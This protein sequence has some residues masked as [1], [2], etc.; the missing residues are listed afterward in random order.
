M[1]PNDPDNED[2]GVVP[3]SYEAIRMTSSVYVEYQDGE[4]L[5]REPIEILRF[6]MS[7]LE[8][9]RSSASQTSTPA[10]GRPGASSKHLLLLLGQSVPMNRQRFSQM[11]APGFVD[12]H[13]LAVF[14]LTHG[15][16]CLTVRPLPR[17]LTI[18]RRIP[19]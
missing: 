11:K 16:I 8:R 5:G 18:Q 4:R 6:A 14:S 12:C 1:D 3:D 13:L 2:T 17:C 9:E 19:S 7:E 10:L 15:S